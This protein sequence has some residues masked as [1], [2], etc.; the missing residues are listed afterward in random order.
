MVDFLTL[1]SFPEKSLEPLET[2]RVP[3]PSFFFSAEEGD[4]LRDQLD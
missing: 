2:R 3:G 1:K 4:D